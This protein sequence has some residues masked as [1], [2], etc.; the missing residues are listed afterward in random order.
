MHYEDCSPR[1]HGGFLWLF[2][3]TVEELLGLNAILLEYNVCCVTETRQAVLLTTT[4][5]IIFQRMCFII[6]KVQ[7]F[8]YVEKTLKVEDII[9]NNQN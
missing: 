5:P 9:A 4:R 1:L 7:L 2:G 8:S 3:N 6:K